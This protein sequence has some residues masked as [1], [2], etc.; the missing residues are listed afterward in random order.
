MARPGEPGDHHQ[1]GQQ[2]RLGHGIG[3]RALEQSLLSQPFGKVIRAF[4]MGCQIGK[5]FMK[6]FNLRLERW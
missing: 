2:D 6:P 4:E 3:E 1:R 5:H